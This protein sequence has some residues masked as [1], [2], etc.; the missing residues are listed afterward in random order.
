MARKKI[1]IPLTKHTCSIYFFQ[2]QNSELHKFNSQ[3]NQYELNFRMVQKNIYFIRFPT[4]DA[5][6]YPQNICTVQKSLIPKK[7]KLLRQL[8]QERFSFTFLTPGLIS[9]IR[10]MGRVRESMNK[11][12]NPRNNLL[13]RKKLEI[14]FDRFI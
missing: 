1:I 6:R 12:T 3:K 9:R 13:Y 11:F 10:D 8:G 5:S 2:V 4:M 14:Q 7:L